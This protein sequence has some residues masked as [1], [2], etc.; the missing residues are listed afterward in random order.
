MSMSTRKL[1]RREYGE[2]MQGHREQW[3]ARAVFKAAG[4]VLGFVEDRQARE[5]ALLD[6]AGFDH[7]AHSH[8]FAVL[9]S[10]AW[11]MA[12]SMQGVA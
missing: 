4:C 1:L 9:E 10:R 7:I 12:E 6:V 2:I 3:S 5:Q 11:L 8:A